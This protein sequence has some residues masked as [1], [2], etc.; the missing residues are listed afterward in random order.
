MKHLYLIRHAKSD[1]NHPGLTDHQRPLNERG[2][3]DAPQMAQWLADRVPP[4]SLL[5]SSTAARAQ[6][7]AL[8]FA[9]VFQL[10]EDAIRYEARI[11]E[12][13][14][15]DLLEI[16]TECPDEINRVLLVGHNP[17]ISAY[18]SYLTN[19]GSCSMPT[20]AM[21]SLELDISS[22]KEITRGLAKLDFL[23]SPKHR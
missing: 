6:Q 20:C 11:Y 10:S 9:Q 8:A 3:T 4:P 2:Q 17:T 12:A 5:I 23:V 7:T 13:A 18:V 15:S 19:G 1:W 22:W 14:L 21:A 16:T